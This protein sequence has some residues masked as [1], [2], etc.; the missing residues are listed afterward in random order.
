[1]QWID[2]GVNLT[3]ES[4]EVDRDTVIERAH[5]NGVAQMIIT[6]AS[7]ESS[8]AAL[9]LARL[10]PGSLFATAGVHPHHAQSL[11]VDDLP[12]LR[13]LL[14]QPE[15]VASGE[16]GLDYCRNHSSPNDQRQAFAWQLRL[17]ADCRKP[18]FLHQRDAHDDFTALLREHRS[19]LVGGVAHCFT[20]GEHELE[21]YL[22]LGLSIGITGWINDERRGAHLI[23]LV[24]RIP[25][26]RLLLETDAPYL[27]PRN[28]PV[29]PASRRNEPMYLS[30]V[31]ATVAAARSETIEECAAHTT[32]HARSLFGLPE[33]VMRS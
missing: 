10:R 26:Q 18:V 15:V 22:E 32:A 14:L 6:G 8:T 12:Q 5:A 11:R 4:F 29:K 7:L 31:G 1:M 23:P 27:L 25:R 9:A 2:I 20:A 13:E 21:T 30:H 17:A 28:L 16:C 3:H 19:A 33:P 24:S